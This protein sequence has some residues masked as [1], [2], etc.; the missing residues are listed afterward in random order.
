M[1]WLSNA[2]VFVQRRQRTMGAC[3][4]LDYIK[5]RSTTGTACPQCVELGDPWV[6]LRACVTCG[7][8]GCCDSSKNR[9]AHRHAVYTGHPIVRSI[10]SGESWMWCFV[11]ETLVDA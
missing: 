11:D 1:G 10:E 7:Q 4:H 5:D 6:H 2:K 9:H 3:D 8:I